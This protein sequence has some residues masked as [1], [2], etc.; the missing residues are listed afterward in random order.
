MPTPKW[1][2]LVQ[3]KKEEKNARI[4]GTPPVKKGRFEVEAGSTR[5][6]VDQNLTLANSF[7]P[8]ENTL[9]MDTSKTSAAAVELTEEAPSPDQEV[10]PNAT[11]AEKGGD[12]FEFVPTTPP[13]GQKKSTFS[14]I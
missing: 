6:H 8:D 2:L 7:S 13:K 1:K 11:E 9:A 14:F 4:A 5:Y 3:A 10:S 12:V